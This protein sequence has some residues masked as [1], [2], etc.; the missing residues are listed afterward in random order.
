MSPVLE[1]QGGAT[2]V[3][4]HAPGSRTA[5][6]L[7]GPSRPKKRASDS[8]PTASRHRH[9]IPRRAQQAVSLVARLR[10]VY[11]SAREIAVICHVHPWTVAR[12]RHAA[13]VAPAI[14]QLLRLLDHDPSL[15]LVL[16]EDTSIPRPVYR[17][18]V[19]HYTHRE[20]L[21]AACLV[22]DEASTYA[23][24]GA[25][26]ESGRGGRR[27]AQVVHRWA[28]EF[29]AGRTRR[30]LAAFLWPTSRAGAAGAP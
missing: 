21:A 24:I 30:P 10:S 14:R 2:G 28:R 25:A 9:P 4:P 16:R 13:P 11:G 15:A 17:W 29:S 20:A 6:P 23:A 19:A 26:L 27:L 3:T 22:G 8:K 1:V 7:A 18:A 12:W 5:K